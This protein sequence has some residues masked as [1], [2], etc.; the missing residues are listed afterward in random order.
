MYANAYTD[1]SA[2]MLIS[3]PGDLIL[4]NDIMGVCTTSKRAHFNS[5]VVGK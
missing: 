2:V 1:I 5:D 3:S 4:I